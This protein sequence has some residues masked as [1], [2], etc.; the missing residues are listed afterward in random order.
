MKVG[1]GRNCS[2]WSTKYDGHKVTVSG[3]QKRR[4]E[5]AEFDRSRIYQF[6]F[7]II[8][9]ILQCKRGFIHSFIHLQVHEVKACSIFTLRSK[10]KN[11]TLQKFWYFSVPVTFCIDRFKC[12]N[13]QTN[14]PVIITFRYNFFKLYF[15][16]YI[17]HWGSEFDEL[18]CD[19]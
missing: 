13:I 9:I 16:A 7:I 2:I 8:I 17:I 6:Y 11:H 10:C 19:V 18:L 4:F 14:L 15:M 1:G 3:A 5:V 12:W